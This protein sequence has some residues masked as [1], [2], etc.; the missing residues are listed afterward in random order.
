MNLSLWIGKISWFSV[1]AV[2]LIMSVMSLGVQTF[3]FFT[4]K[5]EK[6]LNHSKRVEARMCGI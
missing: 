4:L 2:V 6:P 3:I 1:L 5:N